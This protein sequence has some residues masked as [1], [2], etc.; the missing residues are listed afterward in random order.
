[1]DV[2]IEVFG[3]DFCVGFSYN[4]EVTSVI[5]HLSY[6]PERSDEQ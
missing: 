1:M 6:I 4:M 3:G 2:L 5:V